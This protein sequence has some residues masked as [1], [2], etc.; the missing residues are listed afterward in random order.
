MPFMRLSWR[1][2]A[3]VQKNRLARKP[4]G[5]VSKQAFAEGLYGAAA[6]G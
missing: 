2:Y 5:L 4:P 1:F 6:P 3:N